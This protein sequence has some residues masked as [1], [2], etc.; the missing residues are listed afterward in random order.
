MDS[1]PTPTFNSA[2]L[3]PNM[4]AAAIFGLGSSSKDLARFSTDS[5]VQWHTGMPASSAEADV[6]LIFGGD[7]T[8]HRHLASL[9]ELKLPVLVVPCGSGNDFAR[10]LGL[11]TLRHSIAAWEKFC[12]ERANVRAIDLGTLRPVTAEHAL[13]RYF[14][15]VAGVGLDAEVARRANRLPSWLRAHGGYALCLP[16]ALLQF[17]AL[18]MKLL[19]PGPS[20]M[21]W[22]T[23]SDKHTA[24]AAFA[25]TPAFGGGMQIAPRAQ[26]DDG[27]LDICLVTDINM[28]KL[29][30]LF[31]TVYFGRHL[32]LQDV[33]YFRA[34]RLRLE[35]EAPLEV[36]ADGEFVC[37]T[38]VEVGVAPAALQV[39]TPP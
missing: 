20:S 36:Y 37:H 9:A 4:R 11:H 29:F 15:C 16:A 34:A 5:G 30:C 24:L 28:F 39:I 1:L 26:L 18:P 10:A 38:P 33:E 23:K 14:C 6:I 3:P 31:P 17:V 8:I 12:Q 13:V 19:L 35:T 22:V 2:T 32:R 25:N 7:G 27:Q 21:E